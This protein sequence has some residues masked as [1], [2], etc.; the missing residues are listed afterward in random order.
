M[1]FDALLYYFLS[2]SNIPLAQKAVTWANVYFSIISDIFGGA[3]ARVIIGSLTHLF[4]EART[5]HQGA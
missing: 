4:I 2:Q 3:V 1:L 5:R